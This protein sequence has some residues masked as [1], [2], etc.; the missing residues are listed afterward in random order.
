MEIKT[1]ETTKL[2]SITSQPYVLILENDEYNTFDHVI[3]CLVSICEHSN[4]QA[5][6]CAHIVHYKGSCDVKYGDKETL[7]DMN[8]KLNLAGLNSKIEKN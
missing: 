5:S 4:E 1:R 7:S 2:D 3:F 6:Q 8:K